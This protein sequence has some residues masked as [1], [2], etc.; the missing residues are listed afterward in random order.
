VPNDR[1][2]IQWCF[3]R[4][5]WNPHPRGVIGRP[6][7]LLALLRVGQGGGLILVNFGSE[8]MRHIQAQFAALPFRR[9]D[10]TR[11]F[12]PGQ[13]LLRRGVVMHEVLPVEA[14]RVALA[15]RW[16]SSAC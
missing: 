12:A 8:P 7:R 1:E 10:A 15:S 16:T 11:T 2:R 6:E 13:T 14:G 9:L 5:V 4:D 3:E